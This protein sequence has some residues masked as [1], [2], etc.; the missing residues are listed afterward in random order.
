LCRRCGPHS[1]GRRCS[2]W[3]HW[4]P[5]HTTGQSEHETE[6]RDRLAE[7]GN[8]FCQS[9]RAGEESKGRWHG[10]F[11]ERAKATGFDEVIIGDVVVCSHNEAPCACA[12]PERGLFEHGGV[13]AAIWQ[14][15]KENGFG[16][17]RGV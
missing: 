10:V 8:P 12:V 17:D 13:G 9:F 1:Q 3:R 4:L 16:A 14:I 11:P 5:R 6:R 7:L 15:N 2:L